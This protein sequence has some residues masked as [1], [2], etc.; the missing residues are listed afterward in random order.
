[1]ERSPIDAKCIPLRTC[2]PDDH[3]Y[4]AATMASP[5]DQYSCRHNPPLGPG[6]HD[7]RSC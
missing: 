4:K 1:M 6:D 7:F 2:G 5:L 3:W